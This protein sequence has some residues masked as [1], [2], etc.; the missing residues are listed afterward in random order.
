MMG[1]EPESKEEDKIGLSV[2]DW[3]ILFIIQLILFFLPILC[4][5]CAR[6]WDRADH[7]C[8]PD[9][10]TVGKVWGIEV[11]WRIRTQKDMNTSVSILHISD[12]K[13]TR[14]LCIVHSPLHA[15]ESGKNTH[16]SP[17]S[18]YTKIEL[19]EAITEMKLGSHNPC[20]LIAFPEKV[21]A[22]SLSTSLYSF[23][24]G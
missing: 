19:C 22:L 2:V 18:Q 14:S 12:I 21:C 6:N 23:Y 24:P 4:N 13:V 3:A 17:V 10:Y 8:E 7:E 1:W 20:S 9:C 11:K 15:W 5:A 16:G